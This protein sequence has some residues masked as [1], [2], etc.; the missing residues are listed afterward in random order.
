M[1]SKRQ[2]KT[3]TSLSQM[4]VLTMITMPRTTLMPA[5]TMT[6]TM[7]VER[8]RMCSKSVLFG[9]FSPFTCFNMIPRL[10]ANCDVG[11]DYLARELSYS[12]LVW[13]DRRTN[14]P[15]PCTPSPSTYDEVLFL[16]HFCC[17]GRPN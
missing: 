13:L 10:L 7:E 1:R 5:S 16:I 12:T 9:F 14:Y 11:L 2:K 3:L 4:M 17:P 8:T 6:W 15:P